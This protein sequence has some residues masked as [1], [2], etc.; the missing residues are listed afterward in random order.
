MEINQAVISGVVIDV[1]SQRISPGGIAHQ[2]FTLQ[3]RSRQEQA[4]Q[5]REVFC[6]I[7]VEM[8]GDLVAQVQPIA[9]ND[10]LKVEGFWDRSSY[11]D[12]TASK[13]ILHAQ[14]LQKLL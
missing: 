9:V 2:R 4:G 6:R 3:H 1:E 11:K 14:Q 7:L 5:P 10:R 12:D 13:L 8:R